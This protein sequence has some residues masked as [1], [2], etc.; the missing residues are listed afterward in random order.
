LREFAE[1]GFVVVEEEE[2]R[3]G[4]VDVLGLGCDLADYSLEDGASI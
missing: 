4:A 3:F 1:L 2:E